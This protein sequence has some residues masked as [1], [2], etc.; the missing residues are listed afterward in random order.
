MIIIYFSKIIFSCSIDLV[1]RLVELYSEYN[2]NHYLKL[3][4]ESRL[5]NVLFC[6]N[7]N[8]L[9][10]ATVHLKSLCFSIANW[11]VR[12]IM[13]NIFNTNYMG[14]IC[15]LLGATPVKATTK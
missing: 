11:C 15:H 14:I 8:Y 7:I 4:L 5:I 10:R 9:I 6:F 2:T 3:T 1:E 12:N 13:S